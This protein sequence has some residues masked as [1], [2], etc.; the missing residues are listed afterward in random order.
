[1]LIET[2][3]GMW[4]NVVADER[5]LADKISDEKELRLKKVKVEAYYRIKASDWE[6]NRSNEQ[7]ELY[8]LAPTLAKR[9]D[10]REASDQAEIDINAL[11]TIEEVNEFTW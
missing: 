4:I 9:Q 8:P 1:M 3:K 6:I 2:T 5:T 11:T 10:I 7:P